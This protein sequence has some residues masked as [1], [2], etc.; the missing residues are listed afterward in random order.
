MFGFHSG[1]KCDRNGEFDYP[2]GIAF[3]K[4]RHIIVADSCNPRV[5]IFSGRGDY[6][7]QFGKEGALTMS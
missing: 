6:L 5:Q 2:T 1:L 3:H 7:S 4:K